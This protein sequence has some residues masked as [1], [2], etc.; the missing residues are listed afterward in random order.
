MGPDYMPATARIC[1]ATTRART[2]MMADGVF[3]TL[4]TTRIDEK[5]LFSGH[6]RGL[7]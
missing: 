3:A 6:K 5:Q 1:D 2:A 7:L 4:A